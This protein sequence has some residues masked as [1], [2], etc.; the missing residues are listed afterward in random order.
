MKLIKPYNLVCQVIRSGLIVACIALVNSSCKSQDEINFHMQKANALFNKD[1]YAAYDQALDQYR[2]V[3]GLDRKNFEALSRM[4]FICA[5]LVGEFGAPADLLKEGKKYI[6][7]ADALEQNSSLL[8]SAKALMI[9]YGRGNRDDAIRLLRNALSLDQNS[10]ML[11][12]SLGYVLLN[13][14]DFNEAS[15][16]LTKGIKPNEIRPLFGLGLTS[17]RRLRYKEA[18]DFFNQALKNDSAHI[19]S[20][21]NKGLLALLRGNTPRDT[22]EAED[23]L[24]KVKINLE[25]DASHNEKRLAKFIETILM[26]R[27]SQRTKGLEQIKVVVDKEKDDGLFSFAAAREYRRQGMLAEATAAI[28]KA[29]SLVNATRPDFAL[30]QA[31]IFLASKNYEAARY[32]ALRVHAVD[33]DNLE[34]LLIVGDTYLAEKNFDNA[35]EYYNQAKQADPNFA[36]AY[37]RIGTSPDLVKQIGREASRANCDRYL[38]L[39]PQ[40]EY[41]A[42]CQ[43]V[44]NNI[45]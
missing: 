24:K 33:R 22:K 18:G 37:A 10:S 1:S 4:G 30:E 2:A 12:T 16:E 27:G 45:R 26:I 38:H 8:A 13:Q 39:D 25:N 6:D 29:L 31:S 43:K 15:E 28:R 19:K 34:S 14:G 42:A 20:M 11:H 9:L 5:V 32:S 40:G 3:Y 44:V 21:L 41:A 23:A 17:M 36:P 35:L 7:E